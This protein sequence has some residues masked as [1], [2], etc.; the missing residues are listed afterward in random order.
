MSSCCSSRKHS[1]KVQNLPC[2]TYLSEVSSNN[3][4]YKGYAL[5]VPVNFQIRYVLQNGPYKNI[6]LDSIVSNISQ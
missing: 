3:F 4:L 6:F 1:Y 5:Q 2:S